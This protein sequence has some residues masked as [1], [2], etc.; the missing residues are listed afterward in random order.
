M[1]KKFICDNEYESYLDILFNS[2]EE[3]VLLS[4]AIY[5]DERD[6]LSFIILGVNKT[7]EKI[8][9][10]SNEKVV[11]KTIEEAYPNITPEWIETYKRVVKSGESVQ[12]DI[13]LKISDRHFKVN[14][15]S[16]AKG[17]IITLFNDITDTIK[18]NEFLKKYFILFENAHDILLYLKSDGSIMDA[19]KT[20][21]DRYGYSYTELLNMNIQQLRHPSMVVD[22]KKQ[23]EV[24]AAKGLVFEGVHVKKDGTS[25][26]VEV[27]SR[28]I[29]VNGEILRIHV[30]RDITDRKE[31]EE[32]I[33][34]LANYDALTGIANRG[35]LM[36]QLKQ[37][38]EVSAKENLKFA[39][40]LFD[41]DKFKNINDVYGHNVGDEVLK[42]VSTRLKEVVGTAGIVGRLGG[43]EFLVIQTQIKD[44]QEALA[45]AD[46]ILNLV[47]KPVK[48]ISTDLELRISIGIAI[49]PEASRDM[50][51]LIHYADTAMYGVKQKGGNSY[52]IY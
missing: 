45:L 38:L 48:L 12:S 36:R 21:V 42:T 44:E 16:P 35:F 14:F 50:E 1:F 17:H 43:D 10:V 9:G 41:V 31:T 25:F 3:G 7:F 22:Y 33:K 20:A 23:M 47:C 30:I 19:N 34:Y 37:T 52:N 15:I 5:N 46:I 11:G 28:S 39:V 6:L 13:Y 4:K 49:Y 40:M 24:S 29:D 26:P 8:F 18:A 51:V 32:K 2:L 27:S